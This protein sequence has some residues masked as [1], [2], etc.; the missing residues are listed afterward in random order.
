MTICV[1]PLA[2]VVTI[3][4]FDHH[5]KELGPRENRNKALEQSKVRVHVL[6]LYNLLQRYERRYKVLCKKIEPHIFVYEFHVALFSEKSLY[7]D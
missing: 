7:V 4:E 3:S 6:N 1:E 2:K 5:G